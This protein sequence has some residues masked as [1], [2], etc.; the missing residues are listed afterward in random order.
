MTFAHRKTLLA[1]VL[2]AGFAASALFAHNGP[3]SEHLTPP[4]DALCVTAE[5]KTGTGENTYQS[6]PN[7][8]QIPGGKVDLGSPT[9]GGVAVDKAGNIYFSMDGGPHGI[10]VYAPDGKMVRAM[11]DKYIGIH[12]LMINNEGGEE[13]IYGARNGHADVL[14]MKLDGTLVWTIGTPYESGKYDEPKVPAEK[15]KEAEKPKAASG[16]SDDPKVPA[17][18]PKEAVKPKPARRYNPTGIAVAPNL[19]VFVVDGYGQNWVHEFDEN[20]KYVKSFGG[21]G[22]GDGQFSTCHGIALD[23]RGEKPLLLICDR[24]NHRLQHFDLDGKFVAVI[25]TDANH[26]PCAVSFHG[27]N[28]AIAELDG[29]VAIIDE[30]NKVV[31]VLGENPDP[32]LRGNF[33]APVDQWKDG[34]FNAPHGLSYDKDGNLYVEDWNKSGRISRMNKVAAT[35]SAQ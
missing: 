32:K 10:M 4:K 23:T 22:H 34:V 6:V 18:K 27:K 13:F 28:V 8:C 12:G 2:S 1:G 14:K 21:P 15:P 30:T 24:A 31:S 11:A 5:V 35:A 33:G 20:Q 26:L 29:R 7:W 19:H 25:T 9:H 3:D 16:K 17:E